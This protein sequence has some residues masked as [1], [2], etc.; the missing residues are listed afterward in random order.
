M[1]CR[2]RVY[3][4][5]IRAFAALV[6]REATLRNLPADAAI[7][8]FSPMPDGK[9]IGIRV[10]SQSFPPID[11]GVQLPLVVGCLQYPAPVTQVAA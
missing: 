10:C 5:H 2:A 3:V 9:C 8:A 6:R 11:F 1:S 7:E 4:L